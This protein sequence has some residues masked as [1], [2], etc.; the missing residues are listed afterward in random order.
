MSRTYRDARHAKYYRRPQTQNE[1]RAVAAAEEQGVTVR[2][3]RSTYLPDAWD[4]K[5][6]AAR[7][8]VRTA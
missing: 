1:R 2:K 5:R 7:W 6:V 3:A 8:E 4:D